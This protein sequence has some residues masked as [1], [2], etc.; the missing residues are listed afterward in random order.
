VLDIPGAVPTDADK[1]DP[2]RCSR[3]I[4]HRSSMHGGC[5]KQSTAVP[6]RLTSQRNGPYST[7]R[8]GMAIVTVIQEDFSAYGF[9]DRS[10]YP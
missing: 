7:Y 8:L 3:P 2:E 9:N 4:V 6:V 10:V 1:A 5:V